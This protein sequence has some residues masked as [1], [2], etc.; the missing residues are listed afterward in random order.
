M[1]MLG[2]SGFAGM[3]TFVAVPGG[4]PGGGKGNLVG[5]VP[6]V[7]GVVISLSTLVV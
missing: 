3:L 1:P 5:V 6:E 4:G 7:P 2:W